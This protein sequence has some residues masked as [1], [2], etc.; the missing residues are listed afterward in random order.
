M[1]ILNVQD[2]ITGSWHQITVEKDDDIRVR[3]DGT[4]L[5]EDNETC[6]RAKALLGAWEDDFEGIADKEAYLNDCF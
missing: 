5:P 2:Q 1:F 4:L 6:Y 3:L